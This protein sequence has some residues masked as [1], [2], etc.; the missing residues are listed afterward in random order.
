V[1]GGSLGE[2]GSPPADVVGEALA[3][4]GEGRTA[5]LLRL[6]DPQ[7]VWMPAVRPGRSVYE[8]RAGVT[9]FLSDLRAAF[10]RFRVVVGSI[11]VEDGADGHGGTTVVARF[12]GVREV[13]GK[14]EA[15][16][17]IRAVFSV[18]G[19]LITWMESQQEG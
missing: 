8:G 10:G 19:G 13:A 12:H 1:V 14:Q 2:P 5:D 9:R 7:V 6:V 3:A 4:I 18:R 15:M 17:S 16:P 11:T